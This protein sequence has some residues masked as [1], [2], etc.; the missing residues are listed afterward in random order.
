MQDLLRAVRPRRAQPGRKEGLH[1]DV[2]VFSLH[3]S[4]A[5]A[6]RAPGRRTSADSHGSHGRHAGALPGTSGSTRRREVS[7]GRPAGEAW[8]ERVRQD[9]TAAGRSGDRRKRG[10][11]PG[12]GRRRRR[13]GGVVAETADDA[14]VMV[15]V[16]IAVVVSV[17]EEAG[18]QQDARQHQRRGCDGPVRLRHGSCLRWLTLAWRRDGLARLGARSRRRARCGSVR[19][20]S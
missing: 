7:S 19:G 3:T 6:R 15:A 16:E 4:A 8:F 11:R 5:V 18:R 17:R 2:H 12:C 1:D 13:Q 9:A 20:P 14:V 10:R